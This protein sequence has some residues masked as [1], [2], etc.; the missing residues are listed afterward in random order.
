[1]KVEEWKMNKKK[2]IIRIIVAAVIV[3]FLIVGIVGAVEYFRPK[4]VTIRIRCSD[5]PYTSEGALSGRN[6]YDFTNGQFG[7]DLI[8]ISIPYDGKARRVGLVAYNVYYRDEEIVPYKNWVLYDS[9]DNYFSGSSAYESPEGELETSISVVKDVGEYWF[10]WTT[11]NR[12]WE[13]RSCT[14]IVTVYEPEENQEGEK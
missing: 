11:N 6:C 1:M 3:G 13:F 10:H 12:D 14:F 4:Y 9:S 8:E 5:E 2:I 7:T